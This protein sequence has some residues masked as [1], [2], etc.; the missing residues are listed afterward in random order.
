[1]RLLKIARYHCDPRNSSRHPPLNGIHPRGLPFHIRTY[2]QNA[3]CQ[4]RLRSLIRSSKG[5]HKSAGT[6]LGYPFPRI[7]S[8]RLQLTQNSSGSATSLYLILPGT[9]ATRD[10]PLCRASTSKVQPTDKQTNLCTI[11]NKDRTSQLLYGGKGNNWRN[12]DSTPHTHIQR[13]SFA[14]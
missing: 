2:F 12:D 10:D 8:S 4:L 6:S 5:N 14:L 13:L 9:I 11:T 1:M 7:R 3:A